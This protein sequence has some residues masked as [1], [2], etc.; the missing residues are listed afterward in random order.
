MRKVVERKFR[1]FFE[2]S[3][4]IFSAEFSQ[5]FFNIFRALFPRKR[6][7]KKKHQK[8]PPFSNAKCP[9]K[10]KVVIFTLFLESRQSAIDPLVSPCLSCLPFTQKNPRAHKNKIGT[11]P[12]PPKPKIPPPPKRGI[13]YGHRFS[14]RKN[15][16]FQVSIKF[17]R[18][19][20]K[21]LLRLFLASK[22][23]FIC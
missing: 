23:I 11:P 16:F 22:V 19:I 8:S 6:R 2:F 17:A 9:G 4:L 15:A 18:A 20:P 10:Y 1:A 7:S 13:L 3:S 14:C 12:P 21:H 5:N